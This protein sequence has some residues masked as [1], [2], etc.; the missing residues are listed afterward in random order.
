MYDVVQTLIY[1]VHD[2]H[3]E[4]LF[5]IHVTTISYH[6]LL[7]QTYLKGYSL[8]FKRKKQLREYILLDSNAPDIQTKT[9]WHDRK[10]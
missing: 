2:E 9:L 5:L 4:Y 10:D 6:R 3:Y 7:K 8:F 1:F